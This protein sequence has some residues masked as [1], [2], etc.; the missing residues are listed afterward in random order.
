MKHGE[1]IELE[2]HYWV[3]V[4]TDNFGRLRGIEI[5]DGKELAANLGRTIDPN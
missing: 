5:L 4:D 2:H 3:N 1:T